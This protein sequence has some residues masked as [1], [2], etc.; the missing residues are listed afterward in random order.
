[1]CF[2]NA[3]SSEADIK[4]KF[5]RFKK[6][7]KLSWAMRTFRKHETEVNDLYWSNA[8]AYHNASYLVRQSRS[9]STPVSPANVLNATGPDAK[10]IPATVASWQRSIKSFQVW[11]R[12]TLIVGATGAL[13]T[14]I[15][16]AVLTA[17][18]SDPA[19]QHGKSRAID[20]ISW[21]K[22]DIK[23]LY[24]EEL[25]AFEKG[26]WQQR[27]SAIAGLFGEVPGLSIHIEEL[28]KIR[29]FRNSVGHAFGR[30][31]NEEPNLLS[32]APESMNPISET[33]FK[34][35]LNTLSKVANA[36]DKH[37][38][39]NHIGE[40]ELLHH[41]HVWCK[42]NRINPATMRTDT[43]RKYLDILGGLTSGVPGRDF[44]AEMIDYYNRV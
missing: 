28:D 41:F 33:N 2:L 26:T 23:P 30:K 38:V 15:Q 43:H 29:I 20:G 12:S 22:L 13:E 16:R 9:S 18:R 40:Y 39:E 8:P 27:T 21:L 4:M 10:R 7:D 25:K 3:I 34:D 24:K 32:I 14:Y 11:A 42:R 5:E 44:I 6:Y 1:M 31:L 19:A 37:L 17:L 35:W 36:V